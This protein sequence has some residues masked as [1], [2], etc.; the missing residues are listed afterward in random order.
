[1]THLVVLGINY[2]SSP[3]AIRER[4][5]IP[6][7]CL[8]HALAALI[9]LGHVKEAVVLSTCNRTEVYAAVTELRPG[10]MEL[11]SFFLSTQKIADHGVLRPNFKLLKDDVA[12]HLFRVAS[13][14]NS[15]VVGEA[16]I[17]SQVKEAY[18]AALHARTTGPILGE[19]FKLA[20]SC[21]KR[22]RCETTM[23]QRAVSVSSASVELARN[24]LGPLY[25][26]TALVV[27]AGRMSQSCIKH[28]LGENGAGRVIV[29]NRH[30]ERIERL[31]G[32]KLP[33]RHRLQAD[34]DFEDRYTLA[35]AVDMIIVA[36]SAPT[37]LMEPAALS[38]TLSGSKVCIIDISVPRNVDPAVSKM[39]GVH[40]LNSDDLAE[41]VRLN[42]AERASLT[43]DAEEIV[44]QSLEAFH[45]WQR[46]QIVA[47]TITVLR[48]KIEEIRLKY[49]ASRSSSSFPK[50]NELESVSRSIVNQI[51]HH[52]T[53]KLKA[54]Q[55]LDVLQQQA[56][57]LRTLFELDLKDTQDMA[58]SKPTVTLDSKEER[59][60]SMPAAT[61]KRIASV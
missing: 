20:L 4:F 50:D 5:T 61:S 43:A 26:K 33:N 34:F 40:L 1:M 39:P 54:T 35:G 7:Y 59:C 55:N 48:Q 52:P 38:E 27:G 53:A 60:T 29:V 16:Q 30:R 3:I 8:E 21:G 13:G 9:R 11:E 12:L 24:M 22:V 49:L 58:A 28:L 15:M 23:G 10:I 18:Q 42:L 2:H 47:P 36:T 51:L 31:L 37:Y 25:D 44:F 19:L 41:I 6:S 32:N 45:A 46:C 57:A 14:L 56:E 17:L